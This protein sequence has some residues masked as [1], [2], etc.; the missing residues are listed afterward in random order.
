MYRILAALVV[1]SLTGTT[2]VSAAQPK[3]P[4]NTKECSE[5]EFMANCYKKG[6]VKFCDGWW[7]KQGSMGGTCMR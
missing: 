3:A 2:S 1:L 4:A 6:V 7:K 5:E